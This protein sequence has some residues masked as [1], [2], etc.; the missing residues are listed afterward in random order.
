MNLPARWVSI[1]PGDRHVGYATWDEDTC[2]SAIEL[3]PETCVAA[4]EVGLLGRTI[5][6]V[7]C[8]KWALYAW[9]EKSMSGNEFLTAQLIGVIKY[10]C[11]RTQ[12]PYIGYNAGSHKSIY[13]MGWYLDM[14]RRD[15]AQ[16][17]WW[18]FGGHAKDAW[19]IGTWHVAKSGKVRG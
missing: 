9:N 14:T 10:L 6:T 12:V 19:C 5:H 18:G 13:K 7:V 1:D 17:P 16:L 8:E 4:L 2:T 11:G 3:T 15:L